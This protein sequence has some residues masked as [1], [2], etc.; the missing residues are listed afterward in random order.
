VLAAF[1]EHANTVELRSAIVVSTCI[2]EL[3]N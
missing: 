2:T 1:A 3:L